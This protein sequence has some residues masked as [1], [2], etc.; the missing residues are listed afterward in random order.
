MELG[1]N[2]ESITP[3][4]DVSIIN[5]IK[6]I[7]SFD[8]NPFTI[9]FDISQRRILSKAEDAEIKVGGETITNKELKPAKLVFAEKIYRDNEPFS[10]IFNNQSYIDVRKLTPNTCKLLLHIITDLCNYNLDYVILNPKICAKRLD[11]SVPT[12]YNSITELCK[13]YSIVRK[14]DEDTIYWINPYI[15]FRGD[16]KKIRFRKI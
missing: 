4:Y 10:R 3:L 15:F 11:I 8:Y 13:T 2:K 5:S 7:P 9:G 6:D 14:S 1:I 16:R 12:I